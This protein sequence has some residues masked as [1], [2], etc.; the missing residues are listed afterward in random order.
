MDSRH[1]P[2]EYEIQWI[3]RMADVPQ[4]EWDRLA[5]PLPTP[6]LEWQ[7]LNQMEASGSISPQAGWQPQHLLVWQDNRLVGAAPL[8][9]KA[10]SAGEFVFDQVWAKAARYYNIDY[11]PKLVGM[12][13]VT[14]IEGYRFLTAPDADQSALTTLMLDAIDRYCIQANLSGC[15]F[16]FADHQWAGSMLRQGCIGW[17]HQG[18]VWENEK[19][20]TFDD[21][22]SSFKSGQRR[23]IRKERRS[24]QNQAIS[25]S[26]INGEDL[27][28][29]H[30]PTMYR[31]YTS[32]NAR[33]G[34]WGCKY[35]NEAFF[36]GIYETYRHRLL[37][38]IATQDGNRSDPIGM[39]MLLKK[40]P[41]L[42]G[43]YWGS[44][45]AVR[46]LHFN[47]CFYGP[48][49]WA[50]KRHYRYFDPGMGAE[51]K[52]RRGFESVGVYSLHRFYDDRL[53]G[54]MRAH[55][56]TINQAE[57]EYI[58]ALNAYIPLSHKN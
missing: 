42:L 21:Y 17:M 50:I 40:D 15:S 43:R 5:L 39:A 55:I 6:L 22:L 54:L 19:Y 29:N 51:H 26:M 9:L 33:F 2:P 32:T 14:P 23:N 24:M 7:W 36:R 44:R 57:Q 25:V 1:P 49:E 45:R 41:V 35:L 30:V 11:F 28:E 27:P 3:D 20:T 18:Y 4:E 53:D 46:D 31:F 48:I 34:P 58:D 56:D 10:H 16:L 47:V 38:S 37:F 13:P 12:S 8:Y 52:A